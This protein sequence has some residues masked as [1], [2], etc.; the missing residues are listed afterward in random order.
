MRNFTKLAAA[1]ALS[2]AI[3][4]SAFAATPAAQPVKKTA[5]TKA[6]AKKAATH[7]AKKVEKKGQ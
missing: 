1:A 6:P 4:G 7:S 3:A 2:V 5:T